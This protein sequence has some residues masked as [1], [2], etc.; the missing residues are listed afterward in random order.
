M[1]TA[2]AKVTI[3][4]DATAAEA[5]IPTVVAITAVT[6]VAAAIMAQ[7]TELKFLTAMVQTYASEVQPTKS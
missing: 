6:T 2:K 7:A 3:T 1:E 4:T 5:T